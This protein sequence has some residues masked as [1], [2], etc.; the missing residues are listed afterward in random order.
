MPLFEYIC[1]DCTKKFSRLMGV[2]SEL[3]QERCSY[4]GSKNVR[5]L[6]SRFAT[7]RSEDELMESI[8]DPSKI[9]DPDDPKQIQSW[10]KQLGREMREDL[11]DDFDEVM[12]EANAGDSSYGDEYGL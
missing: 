6:I 3:Q 1:G 9:G 11:G 8:A 7:I 2:V 12:A 5:R 10:M 4:C